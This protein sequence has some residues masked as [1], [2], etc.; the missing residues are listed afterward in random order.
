MGSLR[1]SPR[2]CAA[3]TLTVV[4]AALLHNAHGTDLTVVAPAVTAFVVANSGCVFS[5]PSGTFDLSLLGTIRSLSPSN[6]NTLG[7]LFVFNVCEDITP[8]RFSSSCTNIPPAPAFGISSIWC[9]TLG[10]MDSRS[11]TKHAGGSL[12]LSITF[13]GGD[14]AID[15]GPDAC[16][17]LPRTLSIDLVCADFER[18]IVHFAENSSRPCG[19]LSTIESRTGCP[20]QCARDPLT[21]RV[22]GGAT[23]GDCKTVYGT[24][25]CVCQDRYAGPYCGDNTNQFLTQTRNETFLPLLAPWVMASLAVIGGASITVFVGFAYLPKTQILRMLSIC[26]ALVPLFLPD[27]FVARGFRGIQAVRPHDSSSQ[28]PARCAFASVGGTFRFGGNGIRVEGAIESYDDQIAATRS[29]VALLQTMWVDHGLV[30]DIFFITYNHSFVRDLK[31]VLSDAWPHRLALFRVLDKPLGWPALYAQVLE[32]AL[33]IATLNATPYDVL[34][35]IRADMWLKPYFTRAFDPL[36]S[37]RILFASLMDNV[38]ATD[39]RGYAKGRPWVNELALSVPRKYFSALR[40]GDAVLRGQALH[41]HG[42]FL[43]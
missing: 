41:G 7:W 36:D 29:H 38:H 23:H 2:S 40:P 33:P 32:A 24:T 3:S 34:H 11:I 39:P 15:A 17:N 4:S 43:Q 28:I 13:H 6:E 16:G 20:L 18:P 42:M 25:A 9:R 27:R 19:Y 35:Y 14:M 30:C 21:G 37:D 26:F 10:R 12:G 1:R 8:A 22:C 31:A 5:T